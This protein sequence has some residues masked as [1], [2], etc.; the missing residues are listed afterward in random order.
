[1]VEYDVKCNRNKF[2]QRI[3]MKGKI[4]KFFK[5]I[6]LGVILGVAC[7]ILGT[8]FAKAVSFVTSF[9]EQ[10]GYIIFLLPFGAIF[11][12]YLYRFLKVRG[13]GTSKIF[14]TVKTDETVSPLITP[15]VF[16]GTVTSHLFGASAGREGA[17]LQMG[18]GL[19]S[20][21][22]KT[23]KLDENSKR[24]MTI[25]G[26]GA[27]FSAIFGTPIGACVF[28]V[29]VIHKREYIKAIFPAFLSSV[30]A[31]V[32]AFWLGVRPE[33][34]TV[35]VLP[36]VSVITVLKIIFIAILCGAVSILFCS[37]L[38]YG[39]KLFKKVFK[40]DLF[41]G[42]AGAVILII[43][44]CVIG[45]MDYNGSGISLINRVFEGEHI[46]SWDFL[47]KIIFTAVTVSAG[48]KGGEIIPT[49]CIGTTFG[50]VMASMLGLNPAFG[51][52][53]GM[54]ALFAGVTNCPIAT[55]FLCLEIFG[56]KGI[57]YFILTIVFT[58]IASGKYNLYN[59]DRGFVFKK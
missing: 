47:L 44:T 37:A 14:E 41:C 21:L 12:V 33:R 57:G 55:V 15:A 5:W 53:I 54:G 10:N 29:E 31:F 50:A 6:L 16:F 22:C 1:M 8:V 28:A 18:G 13:V 49:F 46:K 17:A 24:I 25:C 45:N 43:L 38:H 39:E 4:Y 7:G 58:F 35:S 26:M 23:F 2:G 40:T 36:T 52:A 27:F 11:T 30:T 48:F 9:R 3:S 19:A 32:T 42:L 34:F 59:G 20:L 51:G 56:F